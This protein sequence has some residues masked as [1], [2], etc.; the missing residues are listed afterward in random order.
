MDQPGAIPAGLIQGFWQS[1]VEKIGVTRHMS[2]K[3]FLAG[4]VMK[5]VGLDRTDRRRDP[6]DDRAPQHVDA[7]RHQRRAGVVWALIVEAGDPRSRD[8][9]AVERLAP[10]TRPKGEG[11]HVVGGP[12]QRRGRGS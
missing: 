9:H 12:A 2:G 8:I 3:E 5:D 11:V 6:V 7:A 4:K 1:D 10:S